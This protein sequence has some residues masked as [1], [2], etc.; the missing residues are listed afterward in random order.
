MTTA[1]PSPAARGAGPPV[2]LLRLARE[3]LFIG[4]TGFGGNL[5]L[6]VHKRIVEQRGWLDEAE[7]AA[8]TEAAAIAPGGTSTALL[9]GVARRLC[10]IP[11]VVLGLFCVLAPG[12]LFVISFL[13]LYETHQDERW[14]RGLLEG[15]AAG[16]I[17]SALA[18]LFHVWKVFGSSWIDIAG[19]AL[20]V[21]AAV[22][23][24]PVPVVLVVSV[25]I[26]YGVVTAHERRRPANEAPIPS[27]GP[28]D[29]DRAA[30]DEG[31]P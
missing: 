13:S 15:A 9:V 23:G 6:L 29:Q 21:A 18:F 26:A 30:D 4:V 8:A 7:F 17:A 19:G 12:C 14:V 28:P 31:T 1:V 25:L 16:G 20:I 2:S 10:G 27:P 22:A 24:V 3:Y 11:G 5:G